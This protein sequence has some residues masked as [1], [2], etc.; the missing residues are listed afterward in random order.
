MGPRRTARARETGTV[1]KAGAGLRGILRPSVPT[2]PDPRAEGGK[3][4]FFFHQKPG[5]SAAAATECPAT[6]TDA[7]G[8]PR[9]PA[10]RLPTLPDSHAGADPR[11]KEGARRPEWDDG[12]LALWFNYLS[13][14]PSRCRRL[15]AS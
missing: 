2:L 7:P 3:K 9:S 4:G 10:A 1:G 11:H 5:A 14:R 12:R 15:R 13:E 6:D 8:I